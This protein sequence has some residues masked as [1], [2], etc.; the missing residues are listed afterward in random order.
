MLLMFR[1]DWEI[2]AGANV[3][4]ERELDRNRAEQVQRSVGA[5]VL[6]A[7]TPDILS[8]MIMMMV[9][10]MTIAMQQ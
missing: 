10:M 4:D 1:T 6:G 9:V 5:W 3:Q 2:Y 8:L 7:V